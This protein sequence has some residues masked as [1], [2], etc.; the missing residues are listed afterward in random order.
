MWRIFSVLCGKKFTKDA[1]SNPRVDAN[2]ADSEVQLLRLAT[3][4]S[5]RRQIGRSNA[6]NSNYFM[7]SLCLILVVGGQL[8]AMLPFTNVS[9]PA[10][11]TGAALWNYVSLPCRCHRSDS[12]PRAICLSSIALPTRDSTPPTVYSCMPSM[13][14]GT[15]HACSTL[16][17]N[18]SIYFCLIHSDREK[19]MLSLNIVHACLC[20][21]EFAWLS[22]DVLRP[23]ILAPHLFSRNKRD[24]MVFWNRKT[25]MLRWGRSFLIKAHLS[26]LWQQTNILQ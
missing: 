26:L 11:E 6:F 7:I 16:I 13:P 4:N 12:P 5:Q 22:P 10:P 24:L 3:K 23:G 18:L 20:S 1:L 21:S 8:P 2:W 14:P 9:G 17:I 25:L 19:K 15:N